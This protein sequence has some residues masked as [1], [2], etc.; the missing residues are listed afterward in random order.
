MVKHLLIFHF[1]P[2]VFQMASFLTDFGKHWNF[3]L[4]GL[5]ELFWTTMNLGSWHLEFPLPSYLSILKIT[6]YNRSDDQYLFTTTS[7]LDM[8]NS[9]S[10][11][12][13]QCIFCL[14]NQAEAIHIPLNQAIISTKAVCM[15][16]RFKNKDNDLAKENVFNLNK[17]N[18]IMLR[19]NCL[20]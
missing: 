8:D 9:R 7:A 11:G 13:L 3:L 4:C 12:N 10:L 2:Q 17:E 20:I 1:T 14:P 16:E 18:L 19:E 15:W 5:T 6:P